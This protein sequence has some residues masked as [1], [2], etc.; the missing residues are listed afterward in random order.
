MAW[1]DDWR[2]VRAIARKDVTTE[3]RAK[4]GFNSV[5]SLGVTILVLLGLALGP[6]AESLRNAAVG[7]VWL[8]LLFSGVLAF[9][10]SFQVE[11]ESGALEPLLQYPGPR[12]TIFAGKLLGNLIFLTLMVAIVVTAG[13]V[14]FGLR[15]PATWPSLL[16]VLAL[17]VVGLVV[18]GTFYASMASRSRAREVLLPL[19][20]FPMLVPVLLAATTASKA[21][22]GADVMH[23]AGAWIRLLIAYDLVF[24]TATF[25]AFEH[26]IEA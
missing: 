2:R 10:R 21:L 17:G 3:L 13:I 23:E 12:W 16:G 22:L 18:L 15:I 9:N 5:A 6:D 26:V 11:L 19:L 1:R 4:A 24:L 25:L 7:A 14:L 8:A 20:L